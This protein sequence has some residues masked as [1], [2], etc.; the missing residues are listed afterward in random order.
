MEAQHSIP[1]EFSRLVKGKLYLYLYD[2][3][4]V[5][6]LYSYTIA[7][8]LNLKILLYAQWLNYKNPCPRQ[9]Q[10]PASHSRSLHKKKT[11]N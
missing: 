6:H 3:Y 9:V 7:T 10:R 1:S 5:I 11:E 2:S 8:Q 4:R